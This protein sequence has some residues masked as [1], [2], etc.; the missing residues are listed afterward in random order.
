MSAFELRPQFTSRPR[1]KVDTNILS[2]RIQEILRE[3]ITGRGIAVDV[4]CRDVGEPI[5]EWRVNIPPREA[6]IYSMVGSIVAH[7][8]AIYSA[9]VE[10]GTLRPRE[11][12]VNVWCT[13][14]PIIGSAD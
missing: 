3:T 12:T 7:T 13:Q 9:H 8:N 1:L 11:Y 5:N 10:C 4:T 14:K 2:L 6:E